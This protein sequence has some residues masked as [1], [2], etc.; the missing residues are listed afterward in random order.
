MSNTEMVA[1]CFSL[2]GAVFGF[3][4]GVAISYNTGFDVGYKCGKSHGYEDGLRR[5]MF[6]EKAEETQGQ[7]E[8]A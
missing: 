7:Q 4:I 6:D 3:M 1:L 8:E 2:L 5:S